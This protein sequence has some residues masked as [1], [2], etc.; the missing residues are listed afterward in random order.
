M[1]A[2]IINEERLIWLDLPIRLEPYGKKLLLNGESIAS[3]KTP[4][5]AKVAFREVINAIK[6]E[7]GY[8]EI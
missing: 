1:L 8:V 5:S 2:L 3:Y 4:E 7:M 6:N